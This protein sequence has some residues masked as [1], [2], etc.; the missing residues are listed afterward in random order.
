MYGLFALLSAGLVHGQVLFTENFESY[1][2]NSNLFGQ[3][4]WIG[5]NTGPNEILRVGNGTYL[6]SIVAAQ[7]GDADI[8]NISYARHAL[9]SALSTTQIT[10]L[11][12]NAYGTTDS[13]E[14]W[15]SAF[16]VSRQ[17]DSLSFGPVASWAAQQGGWDLD[18]RTITGNSGNYF[19]ELVPFNIP[20]VF[21][22]VID[23]P[24]GE[25]YGRYNPN[26][27][28][29]T[30]TAH[31]AISPTMITSI[32]AVTLQIDYQTNGSR[33][34]AEFDNISV[35]AVPEPSTYAM[36]FG[37]AALV[38]AAIRGRHRQGSGS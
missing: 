35:Q 13:F 20:V 19:N 26:G 33:G 27:A 10:T 21:E 24:A 15:N 16:G 31:Y 38:G 2:D 4:G 8:F 23:A 12:F 36:L 17:A 34:V 22:I 28:G 25:V 29:F 18:L 30:E 3:G 7:R 32:D 6:T 37:L 11:S 9:S 1:A 14:S 5:E